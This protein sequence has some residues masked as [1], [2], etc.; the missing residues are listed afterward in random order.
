MMI[1]LSMPRHI[2]KSDKFEVD[3]DD[4]Y[5]VNDLLLNV[6][7]LIEPIVITDGVDLKEDKNMFRLFKY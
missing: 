6:Q 1:H 5:N 3:I 4:I 2:L 7:L